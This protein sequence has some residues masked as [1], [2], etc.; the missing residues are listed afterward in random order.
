MQGGGRMSADPLSSG[1]S[2][3]PLCHAVLWGTG[4]EVLVPLVKAS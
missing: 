3:C 2:L 4:M 1:P